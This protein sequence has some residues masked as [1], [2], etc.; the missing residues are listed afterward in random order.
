MPGEP[1]VEALI[2]ELLARHDPRVSAAPDFLG[3][4]FDLGLAWVHFDQG[5]G[6]LGLS[7]RVQKLVE[8]RLYQAGAPHPYLRNPVGYGPVA[9]TIHSHGR[10][11]QR[12]RYLR[13]LFTGEE[14]WCQL[15]SEPGAGSDL[16]SLAT[17]AVPDGDQWIVNGQKVWTT[18]AHRARWGLLLARSDSDVRKHAGITC[19][20]IDMRAA[21]VEVRPLY[22]M[23]GG[24]EFNEVYL[25]DVAVGDDQ[26]LGDTGQG[27][28]VSMT[29]MANDR[30]AI[31]GKIRPQGGGVIGKAVE[32]YRERGG[33]APA[34]RVRL[35]Q[36][37]VKAEVLRLTNIRAQHLRA[38]GGPGPDS[39]IAKIMSTELNQAVS[40]FAVDLLGAEGMLKP[41]G[42]ARARSEQA[43]HWENPQHAFLRSRANSLEGG[44]TEILKSVLGDRVLGLPGEVRVDKDLPWSQVPRS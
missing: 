25:T 40:S 7:P 44:T 21:G 35:M 22:Q 8:E 43:G 16:A 42:Y 39:A 19:F 4:Q 1:Q 24:A 31:G 30:V 34:A 10:E 17:R 9:P 6:G 36:L 27:W 37:W 5:C 20:I 28:R 18:M 15:F 11:D 26:R 13:P 12:R 38:R 32:L 29:T 14:I 3:A 41:G 2:D 33:T 23:T